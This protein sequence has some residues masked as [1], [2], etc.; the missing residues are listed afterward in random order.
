MRI[1]AIDLGDAR[2]GLA[3]ADTITN[4]ASPYA[5]IEIPIDRSEGRALLDELARVL[6]EQSRDTE[7]LMGYPINMDDTIGPRAKLVESFAIKLAASANRPISLVD[8][9][10]TSIAA[11]AAMSRSG[12]THKQKKKRRDAI[13]AAAIATL[14]LESPESRVKTINPDGSTEQPQHDPRSSVEHDET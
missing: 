10:R 1:L 7:I 13:A 8:E 2:T 5:L 3:L 6:R 14:A 11:D 9:R 4:I 12:L